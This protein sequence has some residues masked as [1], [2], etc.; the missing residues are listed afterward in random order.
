MRR[1][2]LRSALAVRGPP[3]ERLMFVALSAGRPV[4]VRNRRRPGWSTTR[5]A[6]CRN[7]VTACGSLHRDSRRSAT[8]LSGVAPSRSSPTFL[9]RSAGG[10]VEIRALAL[11]MSI[12]RIGVLPAYTQK[13]KGWWPGAL[14]CSASAAKDF[15]SQR[16]AMK[17]MCPVTGVPPVGVMVTSMTCG[18]SP[19]WK[20]ANRCASRS[21][22][23]FHLLG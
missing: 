13:A 1:A 6:P 5:R 4:T 20:K 17:A 12:W 22:P 11:A 21:P 14:R 18:P 7:S 3:N 8:A 2:I 10:G 15:G 23:L 9:P 19:R 16:V